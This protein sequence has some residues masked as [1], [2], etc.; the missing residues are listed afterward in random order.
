M[1]CESGDAELGLV[2]DAPQHKASET[3]LQVAEATTC[4]VMVFRLF[5]S[6]L[7]I[8]AR[9]TVALTD[10]NVKLRK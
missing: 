7:L 8:A 1:K 10:V 5:T 9:V 2:L 4:S 6:F 3:G